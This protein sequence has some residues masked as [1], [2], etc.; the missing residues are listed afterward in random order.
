MATLVNETSTTQVWLSDDQPVF[1][2]LDNSLE[3]VTF[4]TDSE[5]INLITEIPAT[6]LVEVSQE[7][8]DAL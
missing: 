8:N 4:S 5:G 3:T 1:I 6:V 7:I 2:T